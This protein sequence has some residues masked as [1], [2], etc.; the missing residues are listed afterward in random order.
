MQV[1]TS[2]WMP[3][4]V[5][6]LNKLKARQGT[7][8][9]IVACWGSMFTPTYLR[10][11]FNGS[12]MYATDINI[13]FRRVFNLKKLGTHFPHQHHHHHPPPWVQAVGSTGKSACLPLE[14]VP[15]VICISI[16]VSFRCKGAAGRQPAYLS[17]SLPHNTLSLGV[18]KV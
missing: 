18:S 13:C 10:R 2:K 12:C 4:F 14:S 6:I 11:H 17:V 8:A 9:A 7:A 1:W 3:L 16:W 15:S 5:A